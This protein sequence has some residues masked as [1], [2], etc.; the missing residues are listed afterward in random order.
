MRLLFIILCLSFFTIQMQA[1]LELPRKSP[2]AS[3]SYRVGLT[4]ITI[5]Y[6]SPA[7][8]DRQIWGTLVP[9]G[10]V[11]RAGANEATKISFSTDVTI[12]DKVLAAGEYSLFI[13]P[14]ESGKWTIIF[15]KQADQ[16]GAYNYEESKDALRVEVLTKTSGKSEEHLNYQVVNTE[17]DR[18]YIRF[19]WGTKRAYILF[20][21]D[22]LR[23]VAIAIDE[24]IEKVEKNDKWLVYAQAADFYMEEG[25]LELAQ[26][27]IEKSVELSKHS[28]NKWIEATIFA[29][30]GDFKSA[31]KSAKQA[32]KLGKK[33][34]SR[35]YNA[36]Q[37][38]ITQQI[39][40]WSK[41]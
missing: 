34:N 17:I 15:N 35:F 10:K 13:I 21:V 38:T 36:Y 8:R 22:M 16:W 41:K 33:A 27:N 14:A 1:Q 9:Y 29:E 20:R 37:E 32:E 28:R 5:N 3:T 23:D 2:Q 4:D 40:E 25:H 12:E 30:A 31:V 6:G 11:W 7:V 39:E 26:K 18:G 24:A 19:A